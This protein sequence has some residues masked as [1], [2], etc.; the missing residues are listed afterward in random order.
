MCVWVIQLCKKIFILCYLCY[1]ILSALD[2]K[3]I[4]S[5]NF[6]LLKTE[7]SFRQTMR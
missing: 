5:S 2:K 4:I 6:P 3:K 1:L 7:V